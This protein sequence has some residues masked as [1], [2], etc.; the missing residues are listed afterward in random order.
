NHKFDS[1]GPNDTAHDTFKYKANDGHG[2]SNQATVDV[3]IGGVND[4][5]IITTTAG[6]TPYTESDPATVVDN[7]LTATDPDSTQFES[8]RVAITDGFNSG[9]T[10]E[11]TSPGPGGIMGFYDSNAGVLSLTGTASQADWQA[12]LRAVKF[13]SDN[14]NPSTPKKIDFTLNDGNS[15]SAPATKLVAVTGVNGKPT[16]TPSGGTADFVED[17]PPVQVDPGIDVADPD[18]LQL[19]SATLSITG[20][21]SSADGD[22]LTL[23]PQASGITGSYDSGTGVLTLTGTAAVS[24]YE[25][26]VRSVT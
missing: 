9:D 15:D 13:R 18:S 22:T 12:A 26:A 1:L 3:T 24:D 8:A 21:F 23:P 2:D 4:P 16:V 11:F 7:G 14:D 25:D 5:P 6:S 10:L 20:N 19:Q 17:S